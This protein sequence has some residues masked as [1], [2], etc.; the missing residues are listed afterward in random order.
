MSL[1]SVTHQ[2]SYYYTNTVE[3]AHHMAFVHPLQTSYQQVLEYQ[4]LIEPTPRSPSSQIDAFGNQAL[5]FSLHTSHA[6]LRVRAHSRV[7]VAPRS[8]LLDPS[9]S[10]S[11]ESILQQLQYAVG[12]P[13][14][15]QSEFCFASPYIALHESLVAYARPSFPLGA[16]V[17]E[18][19]LDLMHR[20][21]ADFLYEANAT[22]ATTT[23]LQAFALRRGVCQDFA[24]VMIA[25]LRS[26]GLPARYVSG[27]LLTTPP[28]GQARLIG[29]DASHAWV[30]VFC[31]V[32]GWV[33]FDPTNDLIVSDSH[34]TLAIGR[35]YS[36]VPVLHG[37]IRGG[38][39]HQLEVSVSVMPEE[40]TRQGV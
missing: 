3:T 19:T 27:Y 11:I 39:A 34:V 31:P 22:E 30:Q 8:Q 16:T 1:L 14:L 6:Q 15:P 36:D 33:D 23:A 9:A 12:K 10:V 4:L 5:H 28:A 26:I 37:V 20:I 21:H 38:G 7:Q 32:Q 2:T 35:D 17:I 13:F 25:C 29:A 18:G 24:Q 40:E